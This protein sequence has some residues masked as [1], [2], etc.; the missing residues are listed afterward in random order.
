MATAYDDLTREERSERHAVAGLAEAF[1]FGRPAERL[2]HVWD[3]LVSLFDLLR[4]G[5]TRKLPPVAIGV[6]K[7]IGLVAVGIVL[8]SAITVGIVTILVRAAISFVG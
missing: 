6:A 5:R 1:A 2:D 7:L 4:A 8:A 3:E